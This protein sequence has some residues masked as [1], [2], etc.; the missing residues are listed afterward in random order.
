[1]RPDHLRTTVHRWRRTGDVQAHR[2]AYRAPACSCCCLRRRPSGTAATGRRCAWTPSATPSSSPLRTRAG[3][4]ARR[5]WPRTRWPAGR[6]G[7]VRRSRTPRSP[8]TRRCGRRRRCPRCTATPACSTTRSTSGRCAARR[9][10][11]PGRRLAV[12]SALF[13]LL[14]RGRPGA[15]VPA[16][17]VLDAARAAD[18][19]RPLEAGAG[20]GAGGDRRRRAR[21]RPAVR[22]V[23]ARSAGCP[24]RCGDR[25]RRA[26]RRPAHGGEPLQQGA[27]GPAR[28]ACWPAPAPS[29][30]T[31]RR[32]GGG[33]AGGPARDRPARP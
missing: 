33:P 11:G 19:R 8:A 6:A 14:A 21:G 12:G 18:A 13:G 17:G 9:P 15:R 3:R 28:P 4:R 27:Q 23:R 5:R 24:A 10:P 29:R 1:M 25:A 20:A 31:R 30:P 32:G 7:P 26:A 16:L 22:V 2:G